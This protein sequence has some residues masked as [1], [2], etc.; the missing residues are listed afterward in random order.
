M[1]FRQNPIIQSGRELYETMLMMERKA[2]EA[3]DNLSS[4]IFID[5]DFFI[6]GK[7]SSDFLP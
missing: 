3:G 4:F 2:I 1:A 6:H 5:E 7:R